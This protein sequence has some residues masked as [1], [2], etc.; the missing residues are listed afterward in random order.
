MNNG[1]QIIVAQ[2]ADGDRY[3]EATDYHSWAKN[4]LKLLKERFEQGYYD[5]PS[6]PPNGPVLTEQEILALPEHLREQESKRL[7]SLSAE[8]K[9]YNEEL[10]DYEEIKRICETEDISQGRRGWPVAWLCLLKREWC[11]YEKVSLES[12]E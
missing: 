6:K 1:K 4:S 5:P 8:I 12:L 2:E 11:E 9:D 10:E 3:F 7:S